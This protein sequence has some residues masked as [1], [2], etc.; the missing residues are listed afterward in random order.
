MSINVYYKN[1]K[2]EYSPIKNKGFSIYTSDIVLLL[3]NSDN[4]IVVKY[5]GNDINLSVDIVNNFNIMN[6]YFYLRLLMDFNLIGG[7]DSVN[8]AFIVFIL[9]L[10][11]FKFL[12]TPLGVAYEDELIKIGKVQSNTE[13]QSVG[14]E[15]L[16]EIF[17]SNYFLNIRDNLFLYFKDGKILF[18]LEIDLNLFNYLVK[19]CKGIISY[20]CNSL[21]ENRVKIGG[22]QNWEDIFRENIKKYGIKSIDENDINNFLYVINHSFINNNSIN[23]ADNYVEVCKGNEC[24]MNMILDERSITKKDFVDSIVKKVGNSNSI[25]RQ[26]QDNLYYNNKKIV[27][28]ISELYGK[29]I[30]VFNDNVT[31]CIK[32][33]NIGNK[34]GCFDNRLTNYN[35]KIYE[36]VYLYYGFNSGEIMILGVEGVNIEKMIN[37]SQIEI[38]FFPKIVKEVMNNGSVI[39]KKGELM[40]QIRTYNKIIT[41]EKIPKKLYNISIVDSQTGKEE[42]NNIKLDR[43]IDI[44]RRNGIDFDVILTPFMQKY[45]EYR[46]K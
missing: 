6:L 4:N 43:L 5:G 16:R 35:S 29:N 32:K 37:K 28:A 22:F 11:Q 46:P 26:V 44:L 27:R 36:N 7:L 15:K 25:R 23:I 30:I 34:I 8:L 31:D 9:Y 40:M 2:F 13:Y 24:L 42:F 33:I 14:S 20:L 18:L 10:S 38:K 45:F 3:D 19:S 17:F 21:Y 39:E 41:I 12:Y 1:D